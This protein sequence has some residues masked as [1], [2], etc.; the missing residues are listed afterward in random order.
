MAIEAVVFDIGKVLIEWDPQGFY[1]REIGRARRL[2]LFEA[3]PLE[4][5][6]LDIDRGAPFRDRV[7]AEAEKYPDWADE[8]RLW[9]D[10]W[11]D[12][13]S[14]DIP[15]SARLLRALR[16]KGLPVFALT[17]FGVGSFAVAQAAYPVL[18][19]FDREFVSG[20]LR[21]IKPDDA[22][23]AALEQGTGVAP[24]RLLFTD[25]RPENIATAARR[26]WLTHLFEGPE[27]WAARLVAEG[28]LSAEEAA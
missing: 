20:R 5:M 16:A 9:H 14:P 18:R 10:R 3:V 4:A 12:M 23:Y 28:L 15:H 1:D 26:G 6:N 22:I 2:A 7:Y 19:D 11:L 24:Q 27:G 25:D 8:I 17:N 21:A 13:A